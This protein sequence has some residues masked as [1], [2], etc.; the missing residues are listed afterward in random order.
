MFKS[1]TSKLA[2]GVVALV[3]VAGYP[4]YR[5]IFG[6]TVVDV[7]STEQAQKIEDY[8][9]PAAFTTPLQLAKMMKEDDKLIVIG[10]LNPA[11]GDTPISGSF[12]FWRGDYSAQKSAYDYGGMRNTAEEMEDLLS[13]IGAS[14]DSPIVVYAANKH[15][16]AARLY[17]QL[18]LLGHENVKYLDGG[19]NAWLG[20]ELPVGNANPT[21]EAT[22]YVAP[23]KNETKLATIEM[24][25]N[26]I[27]DDDWVIIDTRGT[28]EFDGTSVK[29]GA[30]G[31]GAI[32]GAVHI[33]WTKAVNED[34]TLKTAAE[35]KALY[36]DLIKGKK[37]IS[38]CQSGVRSAHTTMVLE[39]VLGATD[40]YNYDG[41]WIEW[42][43]AF[44]EEG[45]EGIEIMNGGKS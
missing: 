10:A 34:S 8:A 22:D 13:R 14:P 19:L 7:N 17:W 18:G 29:S 1:T 3:V 9:N 35:L 42:S 30:Y 40:V 20:A 4:A 45:R 2:L 12:T 26:A 23:N 5:Y 36:G 44:Y 28:D 37:V 33:N 11:K 16:D 31:P 24:V 27:T 39:E 15:H 43:H 6:A 25:R 32:P 21:V 38:Y 41:S